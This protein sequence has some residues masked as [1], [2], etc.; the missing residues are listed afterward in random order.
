MGNR[1]TRKTPLRRL[2][3]ALGLTQLELGTQAGVTGSRIS[4]AE[5]G[6][7]PLARKPILRLRKRH[8]GVMDR[9]GITVEDILRGRCGRV[10]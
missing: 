5:L 4:Q 2:R 10:A 1:A 3:L 7:S 9:L 6:M 8:R